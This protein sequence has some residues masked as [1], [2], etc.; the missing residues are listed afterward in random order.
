LAGTIA[1]GGHGDVGGG[2]GKWLG[3]ERMDAQEPATGGQQRR[4]EIKQ[5]SSLHGSG[6]S[7]G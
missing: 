1:G 6:L 7:A 3:G 2:D 5:T 4:E